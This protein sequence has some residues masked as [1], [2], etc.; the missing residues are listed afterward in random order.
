[1]P[2]SPIVL[3]LFLQRGKRKTERRKRKTRSNIRKRNEKTFFRFLHLPKDMRNEIDLLLEVFVK[4][5]RI[6][7]ILQLGEDLLKSNL[8]D[9]NLLLLYSIVWIKKST[10]TFKV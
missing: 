1:M 10:N 8:W 6:L 2:L 3:L 9:P 4:N 7:K 5:A